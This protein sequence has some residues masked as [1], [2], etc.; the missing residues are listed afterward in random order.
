MGRLRLS[1]RTVARLV[2][3]G[4]GASAAAGVLLLWGLGIAL[5]VTGVTT[6]AAGLLLIDVDQ[7]R[8]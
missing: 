1:A 5:L 3:L 2:V 6:V 4:G 7:K 8:R